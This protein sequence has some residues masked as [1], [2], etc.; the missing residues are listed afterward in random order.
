MYLLW[1]WKFVLTS[2]ISPTLPPF[3]GNYHYILFFWAYLFKIPRTNDVIENLSFSVWLISLSTMPSSCIQVFTNNMVCFFL[4]TELY[5]INTQPYIL[6]M[7]QYCNKCRSSDMS[8]REWF[9]IL[10]IYTQ[11]WNG[12]IIW[13]KFWRTFI[14]FFLVAVPIYISTSS[15]WVFPLSISNTYYYLSF[16]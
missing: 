10:W 8:L 4:K 1:N 9:H 3:P 2:F 7:Y 16:W 13:F 12:W 14:I 15:A 6:A 5:P 11:K